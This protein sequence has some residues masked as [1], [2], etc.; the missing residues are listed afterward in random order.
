MEGNS[1]DKEEQ[2]N[3]LPKT[4]T[5]LDNSN[6]HD[7]NYDAPNDD[8]NLAVAAIAALSSPGSVTPAAPSPCIT[9]APRASPLALTAKPT[10]PTPYLPNLGIKS[11][12]EENLVIPFL[13]RFST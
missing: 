3:P 1:N 6:H 11:D 9:L 13:T 7:D 2:P 8:T 10:R 5:Q 12:F 4:P